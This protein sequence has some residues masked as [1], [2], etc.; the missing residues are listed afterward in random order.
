M[1]NN[2]KNLD[3]AQKMTDMSKIDTR[4]QAGSR[5]NHWMHHAMEPLILFPA[6][7]IF[8]LVL[9]W[10]ATMNIIK[11]ARTSAENTVMLLSEEL[12]ET[13]EAQV[14]RAL[15]EIDQSL[16]IVK[17]AH[18]LRGEKK[19]L[20]E[21]KDRTLL[22]P[23][24]LFVVSITDSD[25]NIIASTRETELDNVANQ[26]YFQAQ[27]KVD[28]FAV[29]RPK[30]NPD[31]KVWT[32]Q[33]SRRLNS[34]DGK[35]SGIVMISVDASYFV[36]G[37]DSSKLGEHGVLVLLGTDGIFRAGRSG[38]TE[39]ADII[40][41]YASVIPVANESEREAKLSINTWDGVQRYT[42]T[43]ELYNL[44][45][46]IV[47][48][49]SADEQLSDTRRTIN[50]YFWRASGASILLILIIAI[51]GRLSQQLTLSRQRIVEEHIAHA[52]RVEHLAYYDGLTKL[53]N[54][55]LFTK[56]LGQ[57]LNHAHRYNKQLA[58]LFLDLDGFKLINDSFGHEAGD[59]L[60]K[61]VA[62]RLKDCLRD[63][64]TVARLGG[65]EFVV[66]LPEL[67]E[68]KY[69]SAVAQKILHAI[70]K[71]F[72]LINREWHITGSIGISIYPQDGLD[73][74]IL[75]KN[76]D[77]AMYHAKGSGKNNFQFYCEKR[78]VELNERMTLES[79]LRL[80]LER[81][82]F[83]LHYQAKHDVRN[84][85]VTGIE[86]LLRWH[87]PDLG[88]IS[89]RQFIPIA[90]ETGLIVSIGKWVIKTACQQNIAWQNE[91]I[92]PLI[93]AVNLTA[94]QFYDK[95]LPR[96]L[97]AILK[98]SAMDP[99]LLEV[100][101]TESLLM[102][103]AEKTLRIISELKEI[104]IRIAIDDFGISYASL[105]ALKQFPLDTIKIDRSLM[106][107]S[108][109]AY[110]KELT[111][112]ILATGRSLSTTVLAQGVETKEQAE[113]LRQHDCNEYQGFYLNKPVPAEQISDLFLPNSN[114][115]KSR[116][117][118]LKL[119]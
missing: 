11:V 20:Q 76:A 42:S 73:E 71:P 59:I 112:A 116:A 89:P 84:D 67:E 52:E 40:V 100:G 61:E 104:G 94:R 57:S 33:F 62:V 35:F 63:S 1:T 6:I 80:A 15:R 114:N 22:P 83:Q 44:P 110:D 58:V 66:L 34:S 51:L 87:H 36:S 69:V 56:L 2:D 75:T 29:G 96:D 108:N 91:G 18:E 17:Y 23:D 60:L 79:G 77:V 64:D 5:P 101:I 25:G 102:Q 45:L 31:S 65:D 105:S 97:E 24:L 9:I 85:R 98:E 27:N 7:A 38:E 86:A 103:D 48:G 68:E 99:G 90:E 26:D 109:V 118:N 119:V 30:I 50:T 39:L 4:G 10:A 70:A 53:P 21:L 41:N 82:E 115:S 81:N 78:N 16:K 117:A 95:N 19:V 28:T 43:R 92:P 3:H 74:R 72:L 107:D 49:L 54:R 106:D 12:A 113:Y 14:I 46:A 47:V 13:Y 55:S 88:E 93:M 111:D 32:L 37:Y 8:V